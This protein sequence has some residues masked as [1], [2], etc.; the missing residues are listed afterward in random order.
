[1]MTG[2]VFGAGGA[3]HARKI[4]PGEAL[5]MEAAGP[6]RQRRRLSNALVILETALAMVLLI[7]TSLL[8]ISFYQLQAI[9]F[10]FNIEHLLA[11]ELPMTP[12][13]YKS[14]AAVDRFERL[15]RERV[16]AIPGVLSVATASGA[17]LVRT[18][19]HVAFLEGQPESQPFY[20]E[21]RAVSPEYFEAVGIR[22]S[23]GRGFLR[24]DTEKSPP[25][26]LINEKLAKRFPANLHPTG[27]L[28]TI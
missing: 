27:Q 8:I 12:A 14:A 2:L 25:V 6:T 3:L 23:S 17:P 28:L 15:L 24:T 11:V 19:N 1:I 7:S 26:V 4:A 18:Y 9:Q 16:R 21:Y 13:R 22:L 20:I 5:K 10:G